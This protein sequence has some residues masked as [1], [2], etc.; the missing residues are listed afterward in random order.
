[1]TDNPPAFVEF[2]NGTLFSAQ[3]VWHGVADQI[4]SCAGVW[5]WEQVSGVLTSVEP[6]QF[7]E[8]VYPMTVVMWGGGQLHIRAEYRTVLKAYLRYKQRYGGQY[9]RLSSN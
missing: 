6:P 9:I 4:E 3:S 7:P 1:M 5:E 8:W 2:N